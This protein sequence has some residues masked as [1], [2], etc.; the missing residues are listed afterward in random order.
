MSCRTVAK[1]YSGKKKMLHAK[2]KVVS[3]YRLIILKISTMKTELVL[4][5]G[6]I[7]NGYF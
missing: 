5:L 1:K 6:G 3:L 7:E 2:K 4:K